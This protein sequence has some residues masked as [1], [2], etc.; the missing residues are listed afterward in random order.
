MKFL[1]I[2]ETGDEKF[3]TYLGF[4]LARTDARFYPHLKTSSRAILEAIQWEQ[5][6]E[7][8][9]AYLFSR[10]KGCSEVEVERRVEAAGQLLDL[11]A[12]QN[13]RMSFAYGAMDSDSHAS[14]YLRAVPE[15]IATWLPRAPKGA[16]KNLIAVVYDERVDI[17]AREFSDSVRDAVE[18]RGY[19][20]FENAIEGRSGFD[21]TGLM[22]ADLVGYLAARV[23]VISNDAQLFEGLTLENY[24]T[25]GKIR[26]LESSH[27][28]ISKI[29]RLDIYQRE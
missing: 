14:D 15:L 19:V 1:F 29:K 25:N 2:D 26:K 21:T 22:F 20:L 11:N 12:E 23:D 6:V 18:S 16:G 7:F 3:K 28:L 27:E 24:S 4:C 17:E 8:K 9:G 13:A 5:G 10:T